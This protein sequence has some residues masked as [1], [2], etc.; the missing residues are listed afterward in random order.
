MTMQILTILT[1]G[2]FAAACTHDESVGRT[3]PPPEPGHLQARWARA[4]GG[5]A[6][7]TGTAVAIASNGDVVIAGGGSP[8][9]PSMGFVSRHAAAT[10]AVI[11]DTPI[12]EPIWIYDVVSG[13]G[14][15][16]ALCGQRAIAPAGST[17]MFLAELDPAGQL[18]WQRGIAGSGSAAGTCRF[19][20]DGRVFVTGGFSGTIDLGHGPVTA[21]PEGD[22][23]VVAISPGGE[24]A[25]G[26]T[27]Q[28]P[29]NQVL[30]SPLIDS[31]G[32]LVFVG[33]TTGPV[34]FG[35]EE[36]SASGAYAM[37][38]VSYSA[39]GEY[40]WSSARMDGSANRL[41]LDG[42][43]RFVL[44]SRATDGDGIERGFVRLLDGADGALLDNN[45]VEFVNWNTRAVAVQPDGLILVAANTDRSENVIEVAGFDDTGHRLG[46]S[47]FPTLGSGPFSSLDYRSLYLAHA[48]ATSAGIAMTGDLRWGVDFGSG[49]M[50]AHDCI[51]T[52]G[53]GPGRSG[54]DAFLVMFDWVV[55]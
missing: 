33:H 8:F 18:L 16:L 30:T 50:Y 6:G 53:G 32:D 7:E 3:L 42:L 54:A 9:Q 41:A 23:F 51:P 48:V 13:P 14:D 21:D 39:D 19:G 20:S 43:G 2:A 36:I 25:W 35:G 38:A 24:I 27:F 34:S 5:P 10:G 17:N 52:T 37:A 11:W 28:G 26:S 15:R 22:A 46:G 12:A 47:T 49:T 31:N 40:R 4:I 1:I 45:P 44:V 55:D 29:G